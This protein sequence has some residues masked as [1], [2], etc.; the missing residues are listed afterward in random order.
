MITA[1]LIILTFAVNFILLVYIKR[2]Q[3]I[4]QKIQYKIQDD[5]YDEITQIRRS[6][7]AIDRKIDLNGHLKKD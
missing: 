5:M 7:R 3:E 4:N 6:V 1:I 2:Q